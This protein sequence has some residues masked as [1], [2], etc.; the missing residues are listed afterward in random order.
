VPG[1]TSASGGSGGRSLA[2]PG[3]L[4]TSGTS[5]GDVCQPIGSGNTARLS[6]DGLV[7]EDENGGWDGQVERF[8]GSRIDYKFELCRLLNR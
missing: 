3:Q 1:R 4:L 7:G 5:S 8:C 2:P 6:F